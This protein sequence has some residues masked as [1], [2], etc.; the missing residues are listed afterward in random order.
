MQM[1][2]EKSDLILL[3]SGG[4]DSRLLLELALDM[5]KNPLCVLI[6]YGQIHVKELDKAEKVCKEKELNFSR[7]KITLPVD[8]KLTNKVEGKYT[9]V[10]EWHVPSRNLIFIG[11]AASIAESRGIKT[12]W[13]GANYDDRM[14]LFPDCYQ[15]WV[16]LMNIFLEKNGS[17]PIILEAPLLGMKK[18][19]IEMLA[20]KYNIIKQEVHSGYGTE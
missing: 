3:F 1:N 11:F 9:G 14:N 17:Y 13:Y 8:S 5:G 16:H 4:F 15:E 18:Y 19:M 7:V 20:K 2:W 12:I 10:S 6:D